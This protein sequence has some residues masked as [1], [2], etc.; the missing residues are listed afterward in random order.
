MGSKDPFNFDDI[1]KQAGVDNLFV[2]KSMA[3]QRAT[4]LTSARPCATATPPKP[5]S[6][7][8]VPSPRPVAAGLVGANSNFAAS[9]AKPAMPGSRASSSSSLVGLDDPFAGLA[10]IPK[11]QPMSAAK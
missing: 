2:K 3:E 8:S 9:P 10:G 5:S 11:S 7:A 1:Y 4:G 6:G